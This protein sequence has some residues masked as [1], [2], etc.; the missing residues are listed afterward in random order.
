MGRY[1]GHGF[2]DAVASLAWLRLLDL[3]FLGLV[4]LMILYLRESSWLWPSLALFWLGT[5]GGLIWIQRFGSGS[6]DH[7]DVGRIR[8]L[9]RQVAIAA[10]GSASQVLRLYLWTLLS[11][12]SKLYAFATLVQHFVPMDLWRVL[13][14]I[15]GAELSSVLPFH[16]I[17]G[18]GSYELAAVAALLPFGAEPSVALTGVV[19]LHLFL[20]GATLLF[21]A[22]AFA[23]P[24]GMSRTVRLV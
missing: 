3:H 13:I 24:V 19:N 9:V 22:M 6:A 12:S 8:R 18:T 4:G 23:L 11:W 20:L 17:A 21:A 10:P 1:F 2:L 5:L 7:S 16:G 14:G 15:T